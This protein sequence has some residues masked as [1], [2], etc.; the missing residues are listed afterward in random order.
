MLAS[1]VLAL[2]WVTPNGAEHRG[3]RPKRQRQH[4]GENSCPKHDTLGRM[5]G[6]RRASL[7]ETTDAYSLGFPAALRPNKCSPAEFRRPGAENPAPVV[8]KPKPLS[9]DRMV[10]MAPKLLNFRARPLRLP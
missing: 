5:E 3:V 6:K 1:G 10:G 8:V 2:L 4:D 7:V 9:V